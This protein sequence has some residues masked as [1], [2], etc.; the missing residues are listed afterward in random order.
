[1]KSYR[2]RRMP[3]EEMLKPREVAGMLGI[4]YP[5]LKLW[6]YKKKLR[7]IQT[8]G[9]HHRIPESELDRF[10]PRTSQPIAVPIGETT[11]RSLARFTAT[12]LITVTFVGL[13]AAQTQNKK[14]ATNKPSTA[15]AEEVKT[16]RDTVSAQ[17][18]QLEALRADVQRLI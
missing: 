17:Q 5:T 2:R 9:G 4:S 7:T 8:P 6:I 16:L 18:Q 15:S 12:V 13:G 10:L 14:H 1:M 11:V 3:K